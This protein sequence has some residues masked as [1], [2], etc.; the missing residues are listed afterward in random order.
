[1]I[2]HKIIVVLI[3]LLANQNLSL[4]ELSVKTR[5]SIKDVRDCINQLTIYLSNREIK[6]EQDKGRY[7]V[8]G[9]LDRKNITT[10][11][12]SEELQLPKR[13]RLHLIY[14]YTFCRTDFVSNWHY[15]DFLKV[16]KNTTLSDIRSLRKN[17]QTYHLDI[18]YSR[19]QGYIILGDEKQKHLM[20]FKVVNELLNSPIGL[21]DLNMLFLLGLMALPLRF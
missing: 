12:G 7:Y 11:I 16:S 18:E 8:T 3:T 9:I 15:Q 14:L 1:M 13:I 20:A 21:W 10:L 5:F 19:S 6:I 17:L 2:D 4:Y